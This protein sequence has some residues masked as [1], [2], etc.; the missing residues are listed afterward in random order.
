M[1]TRNNPVPFMASHPGRIL[2]S[3]LDERNIKQKEFATT[4]GMQPSHLSEIIRGKRGISHD[5]ADKLQDA[6]GIPTIFWLNLQTQYEYNTK[7]IEQRDIKEQ[8]AHNELEDYNRVCDIPTLIKRLGITAQ[9]FADRLLQLKQRLNLPEVA[10]LQLQFDGAFRKSVKVGTDPRMVMTW[11]L[12]AKATVSNEPLPGTYSHDRDQDMIG[13]LVGILHQNRDTI[14]RVRQ[15]LANYG[16]RFAIVEKVDKASIDGY[17]FILDGVPCIVLTLRYQ[18]IDNFAFT[19]MHEVGHIVNDDTDNLAHLFAEESADN[20][21]SSSLIPDRLWKNIPSV[22]MKPFSVQKVYTQWAIENHL[23]PW[24][25][26]GRVSHE[27]KIWNF[28]GSANR[29][30]Q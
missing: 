30:I 28:R 12:L 5:L 19:H 29:Q 9:Q 1:E 8:Q 25:V 14:V 6:L 22:Q 15:A 10:S 11:A 16:I 17:S 3:E 23:D 18:R 26:L 20:F 27:F 7:A 21:A 2:K 4:L 24:I 13:E